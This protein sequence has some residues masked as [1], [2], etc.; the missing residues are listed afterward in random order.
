MNSFTMDSQEKKGR[1][2]PYKKTGPDEMRGDSKR[3]QRQKQI[4]K[5]EESSEK[6]FH[7]RLRKKA[8]LEVLLLHTVRRKF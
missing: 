8:G 7:W 5:L 2:L 4:S 3:K 1:N 6:E